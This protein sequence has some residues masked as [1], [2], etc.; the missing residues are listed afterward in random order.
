MRSFALSGQERAKGQLNSECLFGDSNFPKENDE[1]FNKL[2]S[3]QINKIKALSYNV[4]VYI[5]K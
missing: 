3:G 5:H 4:T 1:K 2:K